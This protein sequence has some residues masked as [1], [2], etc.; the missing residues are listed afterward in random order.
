[1]KASSLFFWL[2]FFFF[3]IFVCLLHLTA[4]LINRRAELELEFEV[5]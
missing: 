1:M 3:F 2:L 4:L 5:V